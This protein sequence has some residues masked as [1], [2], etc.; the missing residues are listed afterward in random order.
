MSVKVL[1]NMSVYIAIQQGYTKWWTGQTSPPQ[2]DFD[3]AENQ[4]DFTNIMVVSNF[5]ENSNL[6]N[7]NMTNS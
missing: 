3:R 7:E 2:A 6:E 5:T 4:A 1:C